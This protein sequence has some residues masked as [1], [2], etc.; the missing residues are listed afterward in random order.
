MKHNFFFIK[1][2]KKRKNTNWKQGKVVFR[3]LN[4]HYKTKNY[5]QPHLA[6][7][8]D[9]LSESLFQTKR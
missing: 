8:R 7:Q 1:F 9:I 5:L 2:R 6:L 3:A 4:K